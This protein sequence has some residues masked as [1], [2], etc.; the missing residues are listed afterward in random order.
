MEDVLKGTQFAY[1][2]DSCRRHWRNSHQCSQ[3]PDRDQEANESQISRN[4]EKASQRHF[5]LSIT[6]KVRS[7]SESGSIDWASLYSSK[8]TKETDELP[9]PEKWCILREE[10]YSPPF[11]TVNL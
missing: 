10:G 1:L 6:C 2:R 5:L 3:F 8:V 11:G 4:V 9:S 7:V